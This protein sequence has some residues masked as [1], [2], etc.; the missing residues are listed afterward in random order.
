MG[1]SYSPNSSANQTQSSIYPA[2]RCLRVLK[3]KEREKR[4]ADPIPSLN[5]AMEVS[6]KSHARPLYMKTATAH[7][8]HDEM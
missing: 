3:P 5:L 1:G 6:E 8:P 2:S 4:V 7:Q